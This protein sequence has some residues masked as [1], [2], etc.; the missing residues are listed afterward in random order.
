MSHTTTTY[1]RKKK[2]GSRRSPVLCADVVCLWE[3]CTVHSLLL[4]VA[5][6][7]GIQ[8]VIADAVSKNFLADHEWELH[9][10]VVTDSFDHW[11]L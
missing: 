8:N 10:S 9:D 5:Y 3:W 2:Q 6:L 4:L 7:L 1:Y 11:G